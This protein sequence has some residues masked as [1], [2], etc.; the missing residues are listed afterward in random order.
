M[1]SPSR[2]AILAYHK[3][4]PPSYPGWD[5]WF[6]VSESIFADHL[7]SV[8]KLGWEFVDAARFLDGIKGHTPLPEKTCLLTFDDAYASVLTHALPI[9]QREN[10]PSVVFTPAGLVGGTN[11]FDKDIEPDEFL[12]SW[13]Q[14]TKLETHHCSVQSHGLMHGKQSEL[15]PAERLIEIRDSKKLLDSHL[16]TPVKMFSFPYGDNALGAQDI[17]ASLQESGYDLAFLYHGGPFDLASADPFAIKRIPIG[18]DSDIPSLLA[19]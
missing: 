9:M 19:P 13:E 3:I 12:C 2:C 17:S 15:T 6:Y 7:R 4:G 11:V 1:K 8:K 5:T 14:L 10:C 16:Q 18:P